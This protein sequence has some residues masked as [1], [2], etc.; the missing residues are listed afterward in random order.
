MLQ[1]KALKF[2]NKTVYVDAVK[3]ATWYDSLPSIANNAHCGCEDCCAYVEHIKHVS[4][5]LQA[6][7]KT[8]G[9]DPTKEAEVWCANPDELYYVADY[10]VSGE[11]KT[12]SELDWFTIGEASIG[13][14]NIT[15]LPSTMIPT[16]FTLPLLEIIIKLSFRSGA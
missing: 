13:I 3:T 10:H 14:T 4:P 7:F 1:L 8:L 11:I 9:L 5:E 16:S 6:F 2:D 12:V 15:T